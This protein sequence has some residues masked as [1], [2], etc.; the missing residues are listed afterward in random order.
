MKVGKDVLGYE[1]KNVR[2]KILTFMDLSKNFRPYDSKKYVDVLFKLATVSYDEPTQKYRGIG[3]RW[4]DE[5][6]LK[7]L[8]QLKKDNMVSR[9][10]FS[11]KR[12][13]KLFYYPLYKPTRKGLKLLKTLQDISGI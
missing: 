4:F 5:D 6:E 9:H 3:I 11:Y 7:T 2:M 13:G 8:Q 10:N 1:D 12:N